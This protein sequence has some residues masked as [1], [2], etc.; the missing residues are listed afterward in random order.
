MSSESSFC[1]KTQSDFIY[2]EWRRKA[3]NSSVYEDE[4]TKVWIQSVCLTCRYQRYFGDAE[5]YGH[6]RHRGNTEAVLQGA[7]GASAHRPPLP[8]LHGRHRCVIFC[9]CLPSMSPLTILPFGSNRPP[10]RHEGWSQKHVFSWLDLI[11]LSLQCSQTQQPRRTAWCTSCAPFLTPTS[12]PS[13]LCWS[14]SNGTH[15]CLLVT[16]VSKTVEKL[17]GR[18]ISRLNVLEPFLL[19]LHQFLHP[20]NLLMCYKYPLWYT[21]HKLSTSLLIII[22]GQSCVR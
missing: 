2:Y 16:P 6:Q 9:V 19:K 11:S 5:R 18:I 20:I 22:L 17:H 10:G 12:W 13:L 1:L 4:P 8:R 15:R 14:T 3:E 21:R 7:S